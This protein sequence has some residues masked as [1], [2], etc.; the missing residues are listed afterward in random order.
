[1]LFAE[2]KP[3]IVRVLTVADLH[4]RQALY[5]QLAEAVEEH[6][7][8]VVALVGDFIDFDWNNARHAKG[9]L[10]MEQA[11]ERLNSLAVPNIICV[12]GNHEDA[13]WLDFIPGR[14]QSLNGS[15]FCFGPLVIT[16][17]PCL[18][19]DETWFLEG[20]VSVSS[21]ASDWFPRILRQYGPAARTLW[22]MHEPP[23]LTRLSMRSGPLQGNPEWR[24]AIEHYSPLAVVSGHDHQTPWRAGY[25]H[26]RIA[27]SVC[28]SAGQ[29]NDHLYYFVIDTTFR[30]QSPS[31]PTGMVITHFPTKEVQL[32][33]ERKQ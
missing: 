20:E 3:K 31:L 14:I 28:F 15:A 27:D 33:P 9:F 30:G 17:F 29:R 5:D 32:I 12:R 16:G 22:L 18:M 7:P 13:N 25:W 21:D 11:S 2:D 1:M 4:L 8:D 6:E 26:D 24:K 23:D 10:S 19:G